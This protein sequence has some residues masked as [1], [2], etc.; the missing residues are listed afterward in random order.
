MKTYFTEAYR[1]SNDA[2][3]CIGRKRTNPEV[4][5]YAASILSLTLSNNFRGGY[6]YNITTYIRGGTLYHN[7]DM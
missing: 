2:K 4:P 7:Y 1:F 5:A 3:Y 6:E